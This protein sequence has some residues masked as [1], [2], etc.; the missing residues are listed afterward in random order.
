MPGEGFLFMDQIITMEG[1]DV[2]LVDR[3]DKQ[4]GTEEK[5]SA[6]RGGRL[7]RAFSIF[8]FDG[9]GRM[10]IQRRAGRKYHC[11]GL[12]TNTCCSH[13]RPGEAVERA[14]HRKL[15]QELGF[16]TELREILSFIYKAR[17]KNGLTEHEF[18]HVFVGRFDGNPKPNPE[19]ADEVRWVD[20]DWIEKDVKQNPEKYTPW[21]NI[22]LERVLDWHS[23]NMGFGGK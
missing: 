13:P 20:P 8:I 14:A 18:D 7:H 2:V 3:N 1:E 17:F 9:R 5:I 6:H 22:I 11:A 19:E 16:D 10:L 4:T 15:R 21:F 23:K 12:W